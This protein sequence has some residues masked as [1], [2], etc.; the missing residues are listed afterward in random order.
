MVKMV[1]VIS[2][3][4]HNFLKRERWDTPCK[5]CRF[6]RGEAVPGAMGKELAR[7]PLARVSRLILPSSGP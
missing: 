4:C 1:N 5:A 7:N 6:R 3:F 2:V